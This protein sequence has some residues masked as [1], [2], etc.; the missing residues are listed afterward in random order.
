[1]DEGYFVPRTEIL[2]WV[3]ELLN[4]NINKIEQ[5]GSGSIYCQILDVIHPGKVS[6]SK[7]NWKAKSDY[8]FINNFKILQNSFDKLGIKRHVEVEKLSK[9]KYQ[10]NLEFIQWMKRYYDVNCGERGAN[11]QADERRGGI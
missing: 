10:D 3:N 7:V 2:N 6:L 11:Y 4:L 5:L 9:A 8:E 1:M